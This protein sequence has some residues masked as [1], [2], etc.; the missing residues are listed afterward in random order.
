LAVPRRTPSA[1][2]IDDLD[3]R[4]KNVLGRDVYFTCDVVSELDTDPSGKTRV[5]R[6]LVHSANG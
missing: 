5:F 1:A 3:R 2:E 4:A 6:S